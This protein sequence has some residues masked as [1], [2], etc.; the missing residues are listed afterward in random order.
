[1]AGDRKCGR[2]SQEMEEVPGGLLEFDDER[3]VTR[4]MDPQVVDGRLRARIK[5]SATVNVRQ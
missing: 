4:G 1:M 2:K 5:G 3:P